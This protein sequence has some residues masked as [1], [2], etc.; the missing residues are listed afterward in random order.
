[1]NSQRTTRSTGGLPR[2]RAR[3]LAQ[4]IQLEEK[5]PAGVASMTVFLI[6]FLLAAGVTWASVTRVSETARTRGEVVPAGLNVS[7]QHLEGGLV[8][9]ISIRDGDAVKAGA[10]LLSLDPTQLLSEREQMRVREAALLLEMERLGALIADRPPEFGLP[11]QAYPHLAEKQ[12]TLFEAQRNSHAREIAVVQSQ[13]QQRR[14]ELAR[15]QNEVA[16]LRKE[17]SLYKEQV[18][19]RK[20]LNNEKLVARTELLSV[21]TRLA[22]SQSG[23][24]RARDGVAVAASSVEETEQRLVELDARYFEELEQDAARVAAELAEVA[25]SLI[26]LNDRVERLEVRSPVDGIVQGLN[27]NTRNAVVEPGEVIMQIIPID[28]EL[29]VEARVSPSDIGHVHAGQPADIRIDSFDSARFGTV[30]G[31]VSRLS[32]TTYLD[33]QQKPYYRAEI[34]L[35]KDYLGRRPGELR[36]IPGMTVDASIRTG[37][38]TVLDYLLKPIKRGLDGALGE[39]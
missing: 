25:Q 28:D 2:A 29:V 13:L 5:G 11:G 37:S 22:E 21:E 12:R 15:Q 32:A 23:M 17:L 4:A 39:R 19:L 33:E 6:V 38:K 34:T 9:E 35:S 30:P 18:A 27:I 10:H 26:R 7:V 36:I 8:A 20:Q 1:M 31:E 14:N 16:S 3:F 24:R